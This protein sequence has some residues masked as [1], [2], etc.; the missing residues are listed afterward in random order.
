[1][2]SSPAKARSDAALEIGSGPDSAYTGHAVGPQMPRSSQPDIEPDHAPPQPP[3]DRAS[4]APKPSPRSGHFG[5]LVSWAGGH[6]MRPQTAMA[7][8]LLLMLGSSLFFLRARPEQGKPAR[9]SV[10]E[11]G[12]PEKEDDP[13]EAT[14]PH[15]LAEADFRLVDAFDRHAE[16]GRMA[17]VSAGGPPVE[18]RDTSPALADIPSGAPLDDEPHPGAKIP[19][20]GSTASRSDAE[21]PDDGGEPAA[22]SFEA[23]LSL[24]RGGDYLEALRLFDEIAQS[25]RDP[26]AALFAAR[27]LEKASGCA[28]ALPRYQAVAKQFAETSGDALLGAASCHRS[29][30]QPAEARALYRS[31]VDIPAFRERAEAEIASLDGPLAE[32]KID[33]A[34]SPDAGGE[35]AGEP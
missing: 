35:E 11:R 16:P 20:E 18:G 24:Y 32:A 25:R 14:K 27:A 3:G 21:P 28:K 2:S 5:R 10:V 1:M 19:A 23:A 31:L 33:E 9:I 12:I 7:A 29:L 13:R 22:A 26:Q 15:S 6:A 30:G 34:L 17:R 8:V 4:T